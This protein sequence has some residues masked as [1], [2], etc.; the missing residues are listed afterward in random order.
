MYTC[1]C[2]W[3]TSLCSRKLTELCKSAIMEKIKITI[4]KQTKSRC[5]Q[6]WFLL[7]ALGE[8]FYLILIKRPKSHLRE[9]L[10]TVSLLV[11]SDIQG[12]TVGHPWGSSTCRY[13]STVSASI[14]TWTSVCCFLFFVFFLLGPHPWHI[15][16]PRLEIE[17]GLQ[18]PACTIATAMWDLSCICNLQH[19]SRQHQTLKLGI[20]STSSCIL[21]RFVIAEPPQEFP[22][23]IFS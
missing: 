2:D 21:V 6:G 10:F 3:V 11:F 7:R 22:C 8:N 14:F 9:N 1:M 4:K 20:E 18:L 5:Q 13:I 12:L 23:N 15:E 19:S 17:S 16:V